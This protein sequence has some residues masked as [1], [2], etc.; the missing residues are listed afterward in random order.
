MD[1]R[2][3]ICIFSALYNPSTGG[4]EI[5]SE[6]LAKTLARQ[7]YRVIIV[8]SNTHG[9]PVRGMED[10]VEVIRLPYHSLMGGR[11][12][13]PKKNNIY[14]QLLEE[15]QR[16]RMDHILIN[17]RFYPHSHMAAAFAKGKNIKPI[18]LDH[19]SA[20]LTLGN[21]LIDSALHGYERF[22]THRIKRQPMDFYGISEASVQWLAHFGITAK[23]V[24][25]NALDGKAFIETASSRD[26][27]TELDLPPNSF[28]AVF[29]GRLVPE[30]GVLE[31]L[32]AAKLLATEKNIH[33]L[34]AGDGPL[35][36]DVE[37]AGENVHALG[38]ISQPDIAALLL[39]SDVF[40]LPTR[41]EGF[42]T[43][44]LEAAVC[45]CAPIITNAGGVTELIPDESFGLV[46][47]NRRPGTIAEAI[48]RLHSD[49][50]A[51]SSL[52]ARIQERATNLF[53]WDRTAQD[54]IEACEQARRSTQQDTI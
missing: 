17:T 45:G 38:R 36:N 8:T 39:Q 54:V 35:R 26:L 32:G 30:K 19:G 6:N 46:I 34:F 52:A 51:C 4:V 13:I 25:T 37:N 7:G 42:S 15:L 49:S 2:A 16:Q 53:T 50:P 5:F 21:P 23:G 24:I 27:K 29:T 48:R 9:L 12:P 28:L 10:G 20:Y 11:L 41:S 18:L 1:E 31:L 22:M 33:F 47:P 44:L 43:S 14:R 40:C 3:C